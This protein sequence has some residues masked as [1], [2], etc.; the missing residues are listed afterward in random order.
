MSL[1]YH[2][3]KSIAELFYDGNLHPCCIMMPKPCPCWV[4]RTPHNYVVSWCPTR[5]HV[6][7]WSQPMSMLH[8]DPSPCRCY[9]MMTTH[10]LVVSGWQ[11]MSMLYHDLSLFPCCIMSLLYHDGNACLCHIR[12]LT[13]VQYCIMAPAYTHASSDPL[14]ILHKEVLCWVQEF[15]TSF[16]TSS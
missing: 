14:F 7:S 1:L 15:P 6:A 16:N 4:M 2:E 12:M 11:P 10:V 5:I 3:T 13:H 9:I 8:H